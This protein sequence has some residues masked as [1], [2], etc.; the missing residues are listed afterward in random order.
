ME[1]NSK[2]IPIDRKKTIITRTD[3]KGMIEYANQ[4]FIDISGYSLEELVNHPHNIVRH[5]DMPAVIFKL[6]WKRIQLSQ[7][8]FAIV[9][10]RAK[11]GDY[12]WVTT[13]F[14]VRRDTL[15]NK[16]NGYVAYRKAADKKLVNKII[17][18]YNELFLIESA[19]GIDASEK[20]LIGF[21]NSQN[22]SYD[23]YIDDLVEKSWL[24]KLF[25][26]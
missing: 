8:I 15:T 12:Y 2:E 25:F 4:D 10:N 23:Q 16:V 1:Q 11:N 18:L 19:S 26:M 24:S 20:Y 6:M 22:K 17:K 13:K 7:D 14:E 21:L 5:P 3:L 9:K